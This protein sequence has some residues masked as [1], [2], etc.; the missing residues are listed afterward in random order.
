MGSL[1][2]DVE[3]NC[4]DKQAVVVGYAYEALCEAEYGS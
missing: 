3:L 2:G 1:A 4:V